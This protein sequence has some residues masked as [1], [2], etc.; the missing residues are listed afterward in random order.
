MSDDEVRTWDGRTLEE[1]ITP[2]VEHPAVL[3]TFGFLLGLYFILPYWEVSAGEAIH[4]FRQMAFDNALSYP[5]GG[6]IAVPGTYCELA[7]G[8]GA[9]VRTGVGVRRIVV[10]QGR[11][12][13][14]ELA[15]GR[16]SRQRRR[17]DV[18]PAHHR[19]SSGRRGALPSGVRRARV[20]CA[21]R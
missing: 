13:G 7:A 17:L 11:V 3:G 9:E 5:V 14:V 21:A 12:R 6:S 16:S 10:G 2:Y 4:C 20:A 18:E 19:V 8:L 15:D 1:F